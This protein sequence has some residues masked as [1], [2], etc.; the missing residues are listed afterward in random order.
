MVA[1]YLEPRDYILNDGRKVEVK[2]LTLSN[3]THR[4]Y[5]F[6]HDWLR[7]GNAYLNKDYRPEDIRFSLSMFYMIYINFE[8]FFKNPVYFLNIYF[9]RITLF[10]Q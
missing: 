8:I 3:F 2:L 6:V 9:I 5:K 1:S 7:K 10:L 4:Q